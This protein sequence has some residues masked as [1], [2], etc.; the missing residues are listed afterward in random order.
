MDLTNL[1]IGLGARYL[2]KKSLF[3]NKK[4]KKNMKEK[5]LSEKAIKELVKLE[6]L[7]LETYLDVAGIPTI[8]IGHIGKYAKMGNRI[9]KEQAYQIK[10]EDSQR[11]IKAVNDFVIAP[12]SQNQFDALVIFAFN[13]GV[14]GFKKSTLLRLINSGEKNKEKIKNAF[15]MWNKARVNG[16]LTVVNGLTNR[17]KA[18]INMFYA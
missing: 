15:L 11:F 7:K 3:K 17:R 8:G 10:R 5:T 2:I 9:T 13:V 4:N 16:K 18:E 1:A 6:G 12:I 14:N